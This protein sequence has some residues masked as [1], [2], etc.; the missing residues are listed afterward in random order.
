MQ[1]RQL[2]YSVIHCERRLWWL[3][4]IVLRHPPHMYINPTGDTYFLDATLANMPLFISQWNTSI[5]A[6][7]DTQQVVVN[8]SPP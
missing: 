6:P 3:N 5:G 8:A 7:Y 4:K 2:M 1:A